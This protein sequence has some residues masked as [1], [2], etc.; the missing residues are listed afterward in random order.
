MT[1]NLVTPMSKE[2]LASNISGFPI[3][4]SPLCTAWI[5]KL[6]KTNPRRTK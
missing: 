3:I 1:K 2:N 4:K 6:P 5:A